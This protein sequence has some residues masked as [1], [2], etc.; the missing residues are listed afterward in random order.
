[1]TGFYNHRFFRTLLKNS[2]KQAYRDRNR[3]ALMMIDLRTSKGANPTPGIVGDEPLL[4]EVADQLS[5]IV[6]KEHVVARLRDDKFVILV[7]PAHEKRDLSILAESLVNKL[8]LSLIPSLRDKYLSVSIGIAIY[9][10]DAQK[11]SKL[12]ECAARA[13]QSEP[14]ER[15]SRYRFYNETRE[16]QTSRNEILTSGLHRAIEKQ[17][18]SLRFQPQLTL[19]TG[20][21][22]G[23]EALVKWEHPELGPIS[24]DE[25]ISLAEKT[26]L[27]IPIGAW[28]LQE[29][30]LQAGNW[31]TY[32]KPLRVAVNVSALQLADMDFVDAIDRA[33]ANSGLPAQQLEIEITER[34]LMDERTKKLLDKI[35]QLGV[36]ISID[37]FGTGYSSL[38][39]RAR[40][41]A[42]VLKIDKS[43]VNNIPASSKDCSV[44]KTIINIGKELDITIVA[45]GIENRE[46]AEY[47]RLHGC[48][49]GQGYLYHRP[50]TST[51]LERL[52]RQA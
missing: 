2:L 23:A 32:G 3:V 52:L 45:E 7:S 10:E 16:T 39:Y 4:G 25:F 46:Q 21:I 49:I 19:E 6:R 47:L 8:T 42:N 31:K 34:V 14:T 36:H 33:L 26:G 50:I 43:F 35:R 48:D 41:P 13:L 40:F 28:I 44:V 22:I 12:L 18:F 37:D 15:K 11:A 1:M 30:C 20:E 38:S 5:K 29:A 51:E 24:P 9:P 27:I 17:E